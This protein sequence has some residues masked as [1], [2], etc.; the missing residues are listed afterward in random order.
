MSRVFEALTRAAK[1]KPEQH[2]RPVEP[3]ER[4]VTVETPVEEIPAPEQSFQQNGAVNG[5]N[6]TLYQAHELQPG[7]VDSEKSWRERI[8]NLLLGWGLQRYSNYPIVALERESLASEQ[9]KILRE[10][11]K[12][13]RRESGIKSFSVTSPIKRDGKT[14]VAV[15]LAA[16]LSL[17]YE[18]KVLLIDGDLRASNLHNY[19][20]A[21]QSPGL[22]DYLESSSKVDLKTLVQETFLPGLRFLPSGKPS[23]LASEL[24]AKEQMKQMIADVQREFPDYHIIIDSPPILSTPDPLVIA[25]H[26]DGVLV[27]VRARKT[28]RDYLAKALQSLNSNKVMGVVLNGADLSL[29][30]KYYYYSADKT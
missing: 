18:E 30:S 4:A 23:Y 13:L 10:Q 15:N 25:R 28:P 16:V 2:E 7:V 11:V 14:T 3:I 17:D 9:Y 12:R 8:E 1:G 6:G 21:P 29:S 20:N 19:F 5:S 24:L 22:T 27:V 26:V